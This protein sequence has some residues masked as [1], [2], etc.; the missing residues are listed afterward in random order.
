MFFLWFIFSF[1]FLCSITFAWLNDESLRE[2]ISLLA[3]LVLGVLFLLA[4]TIVLD[5]TGLIQF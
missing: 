1:A 2:K 4:L 3:C 5:I